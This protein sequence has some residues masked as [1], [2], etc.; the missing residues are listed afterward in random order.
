V[1]QTPVISGLTVQTVEPPVNEGFSIP[2]A[3]R[4]II[5]WDGEGMNL[6]GKGKPQHY[7]LF[8]SSAEEPIISKSLSTGELLEHIIDVGIKHPKAV[9]VGYS[10]K[11]D[12]NMI[13]KNLTEW[14][15][16]VLKNEG[17]VSISNRW[18]HLPHTWQY[19]YRLEY[20]PGK[21]FKVT[22]I[23]RT[24]RSDRVTVRIDDIFSFFARKFLVAV[25]SILQDELTDDDR[26]VIEHGK[27]ERGNT[28]WKDLDSVTKYWRAEI[29]LMQRMMV[30]F[31]DVMFRAGFKLN[32]WYG[33]GAI[34]SYLIRTKKLK[35]HLQNTPDNPEVHNASKHAYAGGRFEL[36]HIG[37][38]VGPV[39]GYDINSAYPYALAHAPSLGRDHGGWQYQPSPDRISEF[40]VY[41]I[42]FRHGQTRHGTE[43]MASPLEYKAMPL[44]H[45]DPRGAIS[46]PAMTDGWY[47]SPEASVAQF[48]GK[49]WG[50][51]TIHE[52]WVWEH[53]GTRPFKFLEEMFN[54][55]IELGK[56]NV[57]SMPYKLGPNSMYGKFAQRVGKD[58]DIRPPASHCLPLAGWITSRCRAELYK[59]IM[60]IPPTKLIAVETDG[61]Y[62]TVPPEE[63]H[64][65]S[66]GD[67]LGQ[68]G[69]DT[70][71]EML[72]LQNG[73]YHKYREGRWEEPKS[74]GLDISSVPRTVVEQYLRS[75]VPGEF[76]SMNVKLKD[77]F[78]GLTA[79]LA[80]GPGKSESRHCVWVPGEREVTPGGKGKRVHSTKNCPACRSGASAWDSPHPL[81]IHSAAGIA[82]PLMSTPHVL[83]WETSKIPSGVKAARKIEEIE[84][85]LI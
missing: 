85:D 44:F 3:D 70:Y 9:H 73:I 50:G 39:Y 49:K 77:R 81:V 68:W 64:H 61:I 43:R 18:A 26:E 22:R 53:D 54:K 13:I 83:P 14:Q 76:P 72:Y 51:V 21:I 78:V 37:R 48:I 2:Y 47:W 42:S 38:F 58:N 59:V 4:E 7:V 32:Q 34:A 36:F 65:M 56:K 31:R 60:Q 74:R 5:A 52:G 57:I 55:R 63:L 29:R 41:R 16:L 24:D 35:Q 6:S 45:R 40:G 15:K 75:C 80:A 79:A 25:E 20:T 84:A 28:E 19:R 30:V 71:D 11:Y 27:A 1:R 62:T 8:G 66:F 67:G 46:F 69:I 17:A 33:P 12:V 10:F 82:G 23:S